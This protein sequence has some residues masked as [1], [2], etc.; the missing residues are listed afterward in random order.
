M[1][2]ITALGR[3][4]ASLPFP[5]LCLFVNVFTHPSVNM[6]TD[7]TIAITHT[8]SSARVNQV[9]ER[10]KIVRGWE[11]EKAAREGG[12][13]LVVGAEVCQPPA[14]LTSLEAPAGNDCPSLQMNFQ[15]CWVT[16]SIRAIS[17]SSRLHEPH[18]FGL[19]GG[20]AIKID[21]SECPSI[22]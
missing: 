2:C 14:L 20:R 13:P 22:L 7:G 5:S 1:T 9:S 12:V 8:G 10:G 15:W 19:I 18:Y 6:W 17:H 3:P 11:R 4:H 16:L 21:E